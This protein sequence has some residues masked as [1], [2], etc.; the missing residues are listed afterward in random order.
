LSYG[1]PVRSVLLFLIALLCAPPVHAQGGVVLQPYWSFPTDARVTALAAADLDGDAML[2]IVV[3]TADH[4]LYVLE[5]NGD[6]AWRYEAGGAISAIVLAYLNADDHPEI[7]VGSADG[8]VSLL[9]EDHEPLWTFEAAGADLVGGLVWFALPTV[10]ATDLEGDGQV[11]LL[12]G[13][14]DG[15]VYALDAAGQARWSFDVGRPVLGFWTG[16]LD[17]DGQPEVVPS[18]LRGGDLYVLEGDGR[19]AWQ[20]RTEGEIGLIAGGDLDANGQAEV[21]LLTASWDLFVFHGDGR[22]AWHSDALSLSHAHDSPDPGQL[23]VRDL[24]GDG[25]SEIVAV[26]IGPVST[27]HVFRG[28]GSQVWA[29]PLDTGSNAARLTARDVNGDGRL[30]IAVTTPVQEPAYLLAANGRLLAEY[31]T[32]ATSGPV[33]LADLN[34][35]GWNEVIVGT[36]A[37]VQVFGTSDRVARAELWQSSLL[38]PLTALSLGDTDGDGRGEVVAGSQEGRVYALDADGQVAWDAPL[39]APVLAL[40]AGDVDGDGR[41]EVAVGTWGGAEAAGGQ[42]HL[43]DGDRRIWTVPAGLLVASVAVRDAEI[44]AGVGLASGSTVLLFD[45]EGGLTWQ[46]EFAERVTAVGDDGGQVLVGT[47]SGRVYRLAA[48]GSPAGE[49]DLGAGVLSF[50][51][52]LGAT[53]DGR[54][55]RLD[56]GAP[57]VVRELGEAPRAVHIGTA[58]VTYASPGGQIANLSHEGS[59]WE[60]AVDGEVTSIAAGDL[61]G[62]GQVEIAVGTDRGRVYLFGLAVNQPPLLTQ[63]G[64]AETRT[65]YAYSVDVNDPEADTVTVTLEIWDPSA[66]TW[67]AQAAQPLAR[68]Q[69]RLSWEV[70]DPFDTWDAGRD[71]RFRFAYDDGH[72][73]GII[74]ATLGPLNIPVDP[75]YIYYG[76]Y[77]AGL[78]LVALL[79]S[80]L[81]FYA[82]RTRAYRRSPVGQAEATLRRLSL[83]RESLLPELHRLVDDKD[84]AVTVLPHLPG[85]AREAGESILADLAEG[86]YLILTR[87]DALRVAEGLKTVAGALAGEERAP[88]LEIGWK[89]EAQ[90]LYELLLAALQANSVPRI[91]ALSGQLGILGDILGDS[92][93]FLADVARLLAQL[94]QASWTLSNFE[95]VESSGD[96]IAYL[97]EAMEGLA[98]CNRWARSDLA[99][100]EQT[101]LIQVVANWLAVVTGAL[102]GL[103]GRA[104]LAIALKTRRAVAAARQGVHGVR[105]PGRGGGATG[106]PYRRRRTAGA[107]VAI[108]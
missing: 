19:L 10:A 69:G 96:K 57:T 22:P 104:Q 38:G 84:W 87:P 37:G 47:Q 66:G 54:V 85:L 43:L 17:G 42:V 28:D 105:R 25:S 76:R 102:T 93:F 55:Y 50:G 30:E 80:P 21:V 33:E 15:Q 99:G 3:G 95:Q 41:Q 2:E 12:V 39:G 9:S 29:H 51:E 58:G 72:N 71:S 31:R 4:W 13:S 6:P 92:D 26:T 86:Y 91:V 77:A 45:G 49:Y 53:A 97:A 90:Q 64:L 32:W 89:R 60:G 8:A 24:D 101:V 103:R 35:D 27:V 94:R 52:G 75:W 83:E 67:P 11:E 40:A 79:I 44:I 56:D 73:Q 18:P 20:Q 98:R 88:P 70:P 81:A 65:G 7:V 34:G 5:S 63:P 23:L 78:A 14:Y 106:R 82:R 107:P 59:V 36:E 62:N 46:R 68:G 100:P 1:Q 108:G 74:S 61:N 48:D 16:D